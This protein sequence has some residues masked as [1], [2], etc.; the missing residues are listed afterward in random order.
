[1]SETFKL[2]DGQTASI[3]EIKDV[4]AFFQAMKLP[5][6]PTS[7]QLREATA[8]L[9]GHHY[10]CNCGSEKSIKGEPGE[11]QCSEC[12]ATGQWVRENW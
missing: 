6:F 3:T 7:K 12:E 10:I 11:V 2:S 5:K 9:V 4:P 1:M 8:A